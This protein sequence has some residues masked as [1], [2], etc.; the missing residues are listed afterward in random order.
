MKKRRE[1]P[2]WGW[3][4]WV[5]SISV[6][7]TP[8][9]LAGSYLRVDR[10][11]CKLR[12]DG[13]VGLRLPHFKACRD[14]NPVGTCPG[15]PEVQETLANIERLRNQVVPCGQS[16]FVEKLRGQ[17]ALGYKLNELVAGRMENCALGEQG[18][19]W[20]KDYTR[21]AQASGSKAV[22]DLRPGDCPVDVAK[23]R[24][25]VARHR[26]QMRVKLYLSH[27]KPIDP[28][29][30]GH[31]L[32]LP[33][34]IEIQEFEPT[35]DHSR[36]WIDRFH[37]WFK[38]TSS[39]Y[40]K[41]TA[42]VSESRPA[43]W[44][45]QGYKWLF[46][47]KSLSGFARSGNLTPEDQA[48]V[49]RAYN[50]DTQ[51][52]IAE[53]REKM[54]K[55]DL[56]KHLD[57]V[58]LHSTIGKSRTKKQLDY[59]KSYLQEIRD[60]PVLAYLETDRPDPNQIAEG[61][62]KVREAAKEARDL[63]SNMSPADLMMYENVVEKI[64]ERRPEDCG[65]AE[66][67][68][69]DYQLQGRKINVAIFTGF[70]LAGWGCLIVGPACALA[71]GLVGD[72]WYMLYGDSQYQKALA[73]HLSCGGASEKRDESEA[74]DLCNPKKIDSAR[75][76]ANLAALLFPA[77]VAGR[78]MVGDS[79]TDAM[80]GKLIPKTPLLERGRSLKAVPAEK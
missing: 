63:V 70:A 46:G 14:P 3:L 21:K 76:E 60:L 49:R 4:I 20:F 41:A 37:R 1:L 17:L 56:P 40:G 45:R 11:S 39:S 6:Q 26:P 28:D 61:Y 38:D 10:Y 64:L 52:F 66:D 73:S 23:I 55:R 75:V 22:F 43:D 9:V 16:T 74:N 2:F 80:K 47:V 67:L 34:D 72:G 53:H 44:Y 12:Y 71:L 78:K 25:R 8:L 36:P 35:L 77:S 18:K 65:V 68:F 57:D 42:Y 31:P 79:L 30:P 48:E 58:E 29:V 7:G 5:F 15:V 51:E 62:R 27:P 54:E 13:L 59:Y 69:R 33:P 24:E 19:T 50:A 32:L